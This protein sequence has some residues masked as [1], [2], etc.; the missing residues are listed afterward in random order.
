MASRAGTHRPGNRRPLPSEPPRARP[1][2]SQEAAARRPTGEV[3]LS[4]RMPTRPVTS[5]DTISTQATPQEGCSHSTEPLVSWKNA[6]R[7]A[8]FQL[9]PLVEPQPSQT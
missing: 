9:Q 2:L 1:A 5:D 6:Y 7:I 4:N 3:T 8:G